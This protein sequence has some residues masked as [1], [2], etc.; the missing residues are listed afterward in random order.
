MIEYTEEAEDPP[1]P[2]KSSIYLLNECD[3]LHRLEEKTDLN[4]MINQMNWS[5][6]FISDEYWKYKKPFEAEVDE[7]ADELEIEYKEGYEILIYENRISNSKQ[8]SDFN[9]SFNKDYSEFE[10]FDAAAEVQESDEPEEELNSQ[11]TKDPDFPEEEIN[12]LK[13]E[14]EDFLMEIYRAIEKCQKTA[15]G[16]KDI[17]Q[18]L[19]KSNKNISGL[20]NGLNKQGLIKKSMPSKLML[21]EKG[22]NKARLLIN[23]HRVIEAYLYRKYELDKAATHETADYLEHRLSDKVVEKLDSILAYPK[24]CPGNKV[25]PRIR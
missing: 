7:E 9:I 10:E 8:Y 5:L 19:S 1:E 13:I 6:L 18:I 16:Q 12:A 15:L 3:P 14:K 11:P 4:H 24:H 23:K 20:I 21:T 2:F 25:I 17:D 22:I